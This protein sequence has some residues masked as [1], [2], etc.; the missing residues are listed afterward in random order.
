M[1]MSTVLLA[2]MSKSTRRD[3]D[4]GAGPVI[5]ARSVRVEL[6]SALT[7]STSS[8]FGL[9][10]VVEEISDPRV[11]IESMRRGFRRGVGADLAAEWTLRKSCAPFS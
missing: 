9:A 3:K 7:G 6:G 11:W 2:M 5:T 8:G 1:R 4:S 10:R